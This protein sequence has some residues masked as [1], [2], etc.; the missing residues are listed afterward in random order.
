[1]VCDSKEAIKKIIATQCRNIKPQTVHSDLIGACAQL[2]ERI[3]IDLIPVHVKAHQ[4]EMKE[5]YE[6]D[7][8]EQL[9]VL[10]DKKAKIALKNSPH[11]HQDTER[12]TSHPLS[13]QP[14]C[15][16][17]VPIIDLILLKLFIAVYTKTRF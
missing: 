9:N 1:M 15:Y 14:I 17:D 6:L 2:I 8:L 7:T 10:M 3:P 5:F 13:F 4:D 12:F 11:T 16:K